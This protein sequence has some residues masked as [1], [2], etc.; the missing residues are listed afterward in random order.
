MERVVGIDPGLTGA[1]CILTVHGPS[2]VEAVFEPMPRLGSELDPERLKIIFGVILDA[3]VFMEKV[4]PFKMGTT[5]AFNYGKGIGM[6]LGMLHSH[7]LV[8]TEVTPQTWQKEMHEGINRKSIPDPKQRSLAAA[9]RL[10]PK[11]NLKK[12]ETS[13]FPDPGFVDALLIAEY[14][15]RKVKA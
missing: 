2:E 4:T 11:V 10:F 7:R 8:F 1:I 6:L 13:K 14:G 5:G 9:H 3:K 15:R 12:T